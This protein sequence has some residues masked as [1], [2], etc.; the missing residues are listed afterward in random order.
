[1]DR[2]S[3]TQGTV[4]QICQ[5]RLSSKQNLK[6]HLN[7]HSGE[8]PYKCTFGGCISAYR[9]A[10]QLSNHKLVHHQSTTRAKREFDDFRAFIELVILALD[11][12]EE[13]RFTLQE[14]PYKPSDAKLPL[15][16]EPQY[17]VTLPSLHLN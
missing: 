1:M 15:I 10:S 8:K 13:K 17:G 3:N 4:C 6:Q 11:K 9:H 7:I 16:T 2:E 5:K 12:Q 14:G